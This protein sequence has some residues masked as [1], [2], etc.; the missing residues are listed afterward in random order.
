[1]A[2]AKYGSLPAQA[3]DA[4]ATARPVNR[5]RQLVGAVTLIGA[6]ALAAL[7]GATRNHAT[8]A[9]GVAVNS[10]ASSLAG[11][12]ARKRA[13]RAGNGGGMADWDDDDDGSNSAVPSAVKPPAK[14]SKAFSKARC[15][16]NRT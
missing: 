15:F 12:I 6:L 11:A 1:M 9:P 16:S 8:V 3:A 5:T 7:A 10:H 2:P 14:A 4:E 13:Q